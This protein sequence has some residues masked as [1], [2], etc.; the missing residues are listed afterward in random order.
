[1]HH[2]C[3]GASPIK[4]T[5]A[6]TLRTLEA[7]R[8][9]HRV[10][11]RLSIHAE[12]KKLCHMHRVRYHRHLAE[13]F[14]VA[15]DVYMEIQRCVDAR[16]DSALGRDTPNWHMLNA[17]PACHYVVDE[18]P[19]LQ[20]AFLVSMDGNNSA[21]LVDL[22]LRRGNE[23]PEP[24]DHRS[25]V[26]LTEEY[27]DHFQ[28]EILN[29]QQRS[30]RAQGTSSFHEAAVET[31]DAWVDEI[32]SSD[33]SSAEPVSICIDRWRNAAPETRKRM[34]A[35]FRKSGIFVSVCWHGVLL[36]ICDMVRSGELMKYPLA[37]IHR[38]M[39]V[40]QQPFLYGYDIKCA[41]EKI[42]L[43]SSLS[44]SVRRLG[45]DGVVNG[46]HG[47][48]H[49]RLCQVQHHCKY[50]TGAG[51]EDFETCE[52][53]FSESNALAPETR[54]SSEFHR[55]QALDQHFWFMAADKYA[56]LSTLLFSSQN[57]IKP[58]VGT[59]IYN[60]YVQALNCIAMHE[61]FLAQFPLSGD[62]FEADL[63]EE[64]RYL[65]TTYQAACHEFR[66]LDLRMNQQGYGRKEIADITRRR[67]NASNKLTLK[68]DAVEAFESQM[69]LIDHWSPTDPRRVAAQSRIINRRFHQAADDVERLV[70]MRLFEL[71]KL[72]MSGLGYK[73]RT[74]ISKALKTRATAIRHAVGRYNK[75]AAQLE[76][77]RPA[78][79]WDQI[80][81][82]TFAGEFDLLCETDEQVHAKR[83]ADPTNRQ[84]ATKYFDLQRSREEITRC[85]VEIV[86][87]LTKMRDDEL[88][89]TAA[90]VALETH[91]P[92]LA[93]EVQRRWD[94]LSSINAGHK[95]HIRQIQMLPGYSGKFGPGIQPGGGEEDVEHDGL[96]MGEINDALDGLLQCLEE[97]SLGEE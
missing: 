13:Q 62:D 79:S 85:N 96:G 73:L 32:E 91:D 72:Q 68:M 42:L 9:T 24:R 38:L 92:S 29:T 60:N 18:E 47:H 57:V 50:K 22:I 21:K 65:Q 74:Q 77:P 1:M 3:I 45:V 12:V 55:H 36:T 61:E 8:Q 76:P 40:Y 84:A 82:F 66:T 17:C 2:G 34:F 31:D 7:Y 26:W 52:R 28:H 86:R 25:A 90:I 15:Y 37:T 49:N 56:S 48:A 58:I 53:T 10:C 54:N 64:R 83:W 69:G 97:T 93:A 20:F 71:T 30:R 51:K 59:F 46:F 43:R 94:C 80:A 27:V 11:P 81:E 33:N 88:D 23:R 87:L 75:Y 6:I 41:F 67:T 44:S 39:E 16:V 95:S 70:V 63:D 89:H 19:P 14:R 35:I 78:L 4:P 5:I